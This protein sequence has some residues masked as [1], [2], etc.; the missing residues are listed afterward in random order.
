MTLALAAMLFL[1]LCYF[2]GSSHESAHAFRAQRARHQQELVRRRA[3]LWQLLDMTENTQ[4]LEL[5][6]RRA[7]WQRELEEIE[8]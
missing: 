2:A 6:S 3:L 4:D 5:L 1:A 7:A 8:E